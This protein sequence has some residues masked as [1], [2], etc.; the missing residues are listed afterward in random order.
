[1]ELPQP[2][3]DSDPKRAQAVARIVIPENGIS[4]AIE[5]DAL[6]AATLKYESGCVGVLE[7]SRVAGGHLVT[8]CVGIDGSKGSIRLNLQKLNELLVA[9]SNGAF[10]TIGVLRAGDPN[11][12]L[13]F[14]PGH[15]LGW[16]DTFSHEA[17]L[18]AIGGLNQVGPSGATFQD[19]YY[20]ADIVA[21]I[22]RVRHN[23]YSGRK[24]GITISPIDLTRVASLW[25]EQLTLLR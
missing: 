17:A 20:C 21:A 2:V 23:R 15:P 3:I 13:W 25:I 1:M 14:P 19:G 4:E 22:Q 8:S 9:E 7:A 16:V 5:T 18:R 11:Q 6:F 10:K 12:A 24:F